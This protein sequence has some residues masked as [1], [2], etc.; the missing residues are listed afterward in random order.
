[1][2]RVR[3]LLI[4]LMCSL[5]LASI[6]NGQPTFTIRV[7]TAAPDRSEWH[8]ALLQLGDSLRRGSANRLSL[9]INAGGT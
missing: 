2:F 7:A 9:R 5:S 6:F 8:D 1:M 3:H 4:A